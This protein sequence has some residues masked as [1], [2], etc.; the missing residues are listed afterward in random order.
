MK[1]VD[2]WICICIGLAIT[3]VANAGELFH[4]VQVAPEVDC[5]TYSSRN[6]PYPSD[7]D[8]E[9]AERIGGYFAPYTARVFDNAQQVD[10]EHIVARHEAAQ[11]GACEWPRERKAAFARDPLEITIAGPFVNRRLKSDKDPADWLPEK[12]KCW[13]A[14]RWLAIK[15][16]YHLTIDLRERDA[17]AAVLEGCD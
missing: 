7:L 6:W 5:P 15:R 1:N 9:Y 16:K 4:G 12:S 3:M 2:F 10:I 14:N 13:Y 11:S 8:V 17:L